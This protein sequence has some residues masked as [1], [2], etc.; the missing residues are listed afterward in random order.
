VRVR[1]ETYQALT[2]YGLWVAV[3]IFFFLLSSRRKK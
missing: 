1:V 3:V 2:A